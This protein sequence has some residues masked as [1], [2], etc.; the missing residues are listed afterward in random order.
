MDISY[1]A[2]YKRPWGRKVKLKNVTGDGFVDNRDCRFFSLQDGR[3]VYVPASYEVE[4][5]KERQ[6]AI[7]RKIKNEAGR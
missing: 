2:T 7:D 3:M 1:T 6:A 5:S 4:F